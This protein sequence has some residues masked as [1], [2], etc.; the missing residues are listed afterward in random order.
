METLHYKISI[1]ENLA[2]FD[3]ELNGNIEPASLKEIKLPDPV[4]EKMSSK[5]IVLSGRGPI[6]LY[7][8]MIHHFHPC[9]AV[10]VFDPRLNGAVVVESHSND[11][12]VGDIIR[13]LSK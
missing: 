3:F 4:K 11:Y 9:K 13:I 12:K 1:S 8:F 5:C 2:I 6:W 10:A 7:G